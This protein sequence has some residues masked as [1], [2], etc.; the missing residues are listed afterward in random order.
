M[1]WQWGVELK[2]KDYTLQLALPQ[3]NRNSIKLPLLEISND[4]GDATYQ[5]LP[6][7]SLAIQPEEPRERITTTINNNKVSFMPLERSILANVINDPLNR[8]IIQEADRDIIAPI[9]ITDP[10]FKAHGVLVSLFRSKAIDQLS[11]KCRGIVGLGTAY[12][13][14]PHCIITA[15]HNVVLANNIR[16]QYRDLDPYAESIEFWPLVNGLTDDLFEE[17]LLQDQAVRASKVTIHSRWNDQTQDCHHYDIA[18]LK[19]NLAIGND[20]GC[21]APRNIGSVLPNIRDNIRV[22]GYP[23]EGNSTFTLVECTG[24]FNQVQQNQVHYRVNPET[25]GGQS[26]SAVR[27]FQNNEY[28]NCGVHTFLSSKT[29]ISGGTYFNEEILNFIRHDV[30]GKEFTT[31]NEEEVIYNMFL[32][33]RLIYRPDNN[34]EKILPLAALANPLEGMFNLKQFGKIGNHLSISTGYRK[35]KRPENQYKVEVWFAPRFV[36]EREVATMADHHLRP[37]MKK[38]PPTIPVGIF[39]T[40]GGDEGMQLFDYLTS[41]STEELSTRN[42]YEHGCNATPTHSWGGVLRPFPKTSRFQ[43][44]I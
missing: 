42:L 9:D 10:K 21:L 24:Y 31:N 14:S 26:G 19:L 37:I 25:K 2:P 22:S 11:K 12:L 6:I 33:G 4:E 23:A 18:I 40:W 5:G 29:R 28:I 38:W 39:W 27:V 1:D 7:L 15:A 30:I 36:V 34:E 44:I 35:A 13:T 43:F 3:S 16:R 32:R 20:W 41:L 8:L 17:G